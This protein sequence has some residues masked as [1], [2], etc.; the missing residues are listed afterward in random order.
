MTLPRTLALAGAIAAI[1]LVAVG[2]GG[3]SDLSTND[4][5]QEMQALF[6][7]QLELDPATETSPIAGIECPAEIEAREG[8]EFE[9]EVELTE[10]GEVTANVRLTDEE[11]G[12]SATIPPKERKGTELES[13]GEVGS[14]SE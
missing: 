10:G 11:G 8:N 14:S 2:C 6:E 12:F 13:G 5:E 7:A 4:L 3:T 9:C 1:A